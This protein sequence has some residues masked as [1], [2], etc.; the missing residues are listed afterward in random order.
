MSKLFLTQNK[1]AVDEDFKINREILA[2]AKR[3]V[4][5]FNG[6]TLRQVAKFPLGQTDVNTLSRLIGEVYIAVDELWG[7]I[8]AKKDE[9]SAPNVIASYNDLARFITSRSPQLTTADLNAIR[10]ELTRN[11]IP[12]AISDI[13]GIAVGKNFIDVGTLQ[14]IQQQIQ[15]FISGSPTLSPVYQRLASRLLTK[16]TRKAKPKGETVGTQTAVEDVEGSGRKRRAPRRRGGMDVDEMDDPELSEIEDIKSRGRKRV[17]TD[18]RGGPGSLAGPEK[19]Q[20]VG[21]KG[22]RSAIPKFLF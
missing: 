9:A 12:E 3:Q 5:L 16:I 17:P 8:R 22:S 2:R 1:E 6:D 15:Q 20:I 10:K 14:S 18:I 11:F 4:E 13:V 7:S 19:Y 21:R